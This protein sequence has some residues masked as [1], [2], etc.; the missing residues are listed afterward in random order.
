MRAAFIDKDGTLV[1]NVPYNVDPAAIR[2]APGAG[3]G[4][5]LLASAGFKLFVVSNQSGVARGYFAIDALREVE[6]R[7]R[8]LLHA[9]GVAIEAFYWCPHHP[10]GADARYAIRCSCRKPEPGLLLRASAEHDVDLSGS[11]AIGDILDDVGAGRR[12]GCRTVLVNSGGETEWQ[13]APWRTPNYVAED[14]ADAARFILFAEGRA[15]GEARAR[16]MA[17]SAA[18]PS[19]GAQANER[20]GRSARGTRSER[21]HREHREHAD[22]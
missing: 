18:R 11:W 3:E 8:E 13:M 14:L 20:A 15:R 17:A 12:A 2:L 7:L 4:L 10:E 21:A 16:A 6:E 19:A 5:R 22:G 1:E 9:E